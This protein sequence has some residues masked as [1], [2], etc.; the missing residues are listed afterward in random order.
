[1]K[2]P[3]RIELWLSCSLNMWMVLSLKHC[4]EMAV[5]GQEA[6]QEIGTG[7][8]TLHLA[9]L[10]AKC[11]ATAGEAARS[12]KD[13]GFFLCHPDW[14]RILYSCN[15]TTHFLLKSSICVS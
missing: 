10:A 7:G 6:T 14:K 2:Q 11:K 13:Q 1:M 8:G 3:T 5:W 9:V 15:R 4:A 12:S